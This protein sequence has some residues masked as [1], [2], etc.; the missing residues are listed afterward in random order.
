MTFI[1]QQT[2]HMHLMIGNF[3]IISFGVADH[4]LDQCTQNIINFKKVYSFYKK[5]PSYLITKLFDQFQIHKRNF[6]YMLRSNQVIG[7]MTYAHVITLAPGLL[8]TFCYVL[9]KKSTFNIFVFSFLIVS[10]SFQILSIPVTYFLYGLVAVKMSKGAQHVPA[11]Q[12]MFTGKQ[13]SKLKIYLNLHY[14]L[15]NGRRSVGI[16]VGPLSTITKLKAF[17]VR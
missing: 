10:L 3:L 15:L 13:F 4:S 16:K 5:V 11:I 2:V 7:K 14:E 1:A 9:Y 8:V 6:L 12:M 17:R